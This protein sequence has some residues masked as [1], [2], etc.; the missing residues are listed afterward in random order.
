MQALKAVI[1]NGNATLDEPLEIEGRFE[2]VLV[3]LDAD[4]W[5]ALI[6]DPRPRPE[7]VKAGR[8]AIKEFEEGKTTPLNPDK[9][10]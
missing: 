3:I 6:H 2:A 7:L 9:M 4:P 1:E 10:L 8:E 5:D